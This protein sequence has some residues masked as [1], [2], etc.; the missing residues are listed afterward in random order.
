MTKFNIDI[1]C[2]NSPKK[3][4]IKAFNIAYAKGDADFI[5]EHVSDE[6]LWTIHGDKKIEG[7]KAFSEVIHKMK[8]HVA[9]ELTLHS[10]I[11]NNDEGSVNGEI[12]IGNTTYAFCDVYSFDNST[13]NRIKKMNSYVVKL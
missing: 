3:E 1:D 10:I 5:I 7:K 11:T 9:D 13:H 12:K 8:V 2:S 4:F 6:I